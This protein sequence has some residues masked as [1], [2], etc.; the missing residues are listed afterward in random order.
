M[1]MSVV[2]VFIAVRAVHRGRQLNVGWV[3]GGEQWGG[4]QCSSFIWLQ[5]K[6]PYYPAM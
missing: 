5:N 6:L 1:C 2:G 3:R 4:E